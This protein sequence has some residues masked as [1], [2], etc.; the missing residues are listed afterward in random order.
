MPFKSARFSYRA[1]AG[2]DHAMELLLAVTMTVRTLSLLSLWSL[3]VAIWSFYANLQNSDPM[4][5]SPNG[6]QVI[7]G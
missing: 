4:I 2:G 1:A 5:E 6:V 7:E 3:V